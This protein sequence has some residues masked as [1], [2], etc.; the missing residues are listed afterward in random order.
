MN[1]NFIFHHIS[2]KIFIY[3]SLLLKKKIQ[4]L[5]PAKR[6]LQIY[7]MRYHL[8]IS[9]SHPYPGIIQFYISSNKSSWDGAKGGSNRVV[10]LEA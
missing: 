1:Q 2:R 5:L 10:K 4:L 8:T 3:P 6:Y 7:V 9:T